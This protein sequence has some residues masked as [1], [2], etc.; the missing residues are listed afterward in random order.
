MLTK[1]IGEEYTMH[2]F[3]KK[4]VEQLDQVLKLLSEALDM[5]YINFSDSKWKDKSS[6][7][8]FLNGA[9]NYLKILDKR[10]EVR[11]R[12]GDDDLQLTQNDV[13]MIRFFLNDIDM[14][15]YVTHKPYYKDYQAKYGKKDDAKEA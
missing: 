3:Y 6:F 7:D 8:L 14:M 15:D 12:L 11:E 9:K 4:Q 1:Q 2:E 13:E 5:T 10:I